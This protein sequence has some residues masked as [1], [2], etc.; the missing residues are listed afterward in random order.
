M[1]EASQ[2]ERRA[3]EVVAEY[4]RQ[5]VDSVLVEEDTLEEPFGLGVL[6]RISGVPAKRRNE[7]PLGGKLAVGRLPGHR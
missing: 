1:I 2:A 3:R 4:S 6:L 7:R 5:G